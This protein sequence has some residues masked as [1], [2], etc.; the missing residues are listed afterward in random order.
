M[1]VRNI[2]WDHHR[3]GIGGDGFDIAYFEY[4][5]DGGDWLRMV[6]VVFG[7]DSDKPDNFCPKTAVLDID[8]LNK[9]VIEFGYPPYGNSWRGDNFF[10]ELQPSLAKTYIDQYGKY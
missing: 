2:K 10:Q 5:E 9:E 6:A 4:S 8:Q 7:F 3:N 1:I